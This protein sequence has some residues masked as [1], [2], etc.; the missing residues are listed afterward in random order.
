MPVHDFILDPIVLSFFKKG[1]SCTVLDLGCGYGL[2]GT[3]LRYERDHRGII[4][5]L[6]AYGP[7]LR[8]IKRY[9]GSIYDAFIVADARYLPFRDGAVDV[10]FASEIIEHL[11]KQGGYRIIEEA[12]RAAKKRIIITTPRGHIPQESQSENDLEAHK[13]GWSEPDFV[14][15]GYSIVYAG[16]VQMMVRKSRLRGIVGLVNAAL[17]MIPESLR[18]KLPK[19]ELIAYKDLIK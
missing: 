17:G 19:Y 18:K 4:I 7:Y 11:P 10:V 1:D 5:G 9:S 15:L 16:S 12:E 2:F 13:S 6:D 3:L 14:R 8:K